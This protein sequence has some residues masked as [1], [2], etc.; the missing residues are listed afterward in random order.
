MKYLIITVVL[1]V[2]LK[3]YAF[4][5]QSD[6][7]ETIQSGRFIL[8]NEFDTYR[9]KSLVADKP[10]V[11][12]GVGTFRVLL[13]AS[14]GNFSRVI[15]FDHDAL[16]ARFNRYHLELIKSL[17]KLGWSLDAQRIQYVALLNHRYL[18]PKQVA[19]IAKDSS[20]NDI[21]RMAILLEQ[22][23]DMPSI[24]LE[25]LP[26][27]LRAPVQEIHNTIMEAARRCHDG[28]QV[29][30][31]AQ[32][33]W[34]SIKTFKKFIEPSNRFEAIYWGTNEKWK[35]IQDLVELDKINVVKGSLSGPTTLKRLGDYVRTKNEKFC[36]ADISNALDSIFYSQ[37]QHLRKD[38]SSEC[39]ENLS[40]LPW[41]QDAYLLSTKL[42]NSKNWTWDF[43]GLEI[44]ALSEIVRKKEGIKIHQM[45]W[46]NSLKFE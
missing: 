7:G 36:V 41:T 43:Y 15:M 2:G 27:V 6:N 21:A 22:L 26:E 11:L 14:M 28:E 30:S 45:I 23:W 5:F 40:S 33:T 17:G 8:P 44:T 19:N 35:K 1:F 3:T 46:E 4:D 38:A 16:I 34:N 24:T 42:I 10:G 32:I 25:E 18:N 37:E 29:K 20:N 13:L 39:I 12:I 9:Y 31:R